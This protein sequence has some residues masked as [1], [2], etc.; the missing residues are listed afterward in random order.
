MDATARFANVKARLFSHVATLDLGAAVYYEGDTSARTDTEESWVR[1]AVR[2]LSEDWSGHHSASYRALDARVL[3]IADVFVRDAAASG[4]VHDA[5][6]AD[7]IADTLTDALRALSLDFLDYSSNPASPAT[8]AD[9]RLRAIEA[10]AQT[11]LPADGG[12]SRRQVS[13]EVRWIARHAA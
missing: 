12:W 10:P 4:E 13:V 5:Y 11:W 6:L 8:V 2:P 9:A 7:R 3:L 1:L